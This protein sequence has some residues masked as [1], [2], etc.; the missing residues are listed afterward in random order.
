MRFFGKHLSLQRK[1]FLSLSL[2]TA[3]LCVFFSA[4]FYVH[5]TSV[6]EE[7]V[8]EKAEL[9]LVQVDAVQD[10]VRSVLRPRMFERHPNDFVIEAMSSSYISRN[11]MDRVGERAL[12]L[13]YRRVA[14]GARNEDSEANDIERMLI[15]RFRSDESLKKW[16]GTLRMRN[17][18][19]YVISRPVRFSKPCMQCHGSVDD[20]PV[21]LVRM[22]GNNGFGHTL[23]G[24]DGLDFIAFPAGATEAQLKGV[25]V[26]YFILFALCA[27]FFFTAALVSFRILVVRRLYALATS[28]R[29][30]LN[31]G[32]RTDIFDR[33]NEKDEVEE[34][35]ECFEQVA[36]HLVD[37]RLQLQSYADNLKTMV[38]ARTSE[39]SHEARERQADVA[40]FVHLFEDM[41]GTRTNE[42]LWGI[43]LPRI[44]RRFGAQCIA[45]ICTFGARRHYIW[46]H[47]EAMPDLPEPLTPFIVES[48]VQV[49]GRTIFIPVEAQ[50]GATEG[51][52]CLVW[53]DE[54][55][56]TKQNLAVL[57]ALG[58]QLGTVAENIMAL[59]RVMRQMDL[60][61]A[62]FDGV[63]DPLVLFDDAGQV[64]IAND[65]ARRLAQELYEQKMESL[66]EGK[67][68]AHEPSPQGSSVQPAPTI[69]GQ[70]NATGNLIS[71]LLGEETMDVCQQVLQGETASRTVMHSHGRSFLVH[72][73]PV[74]AMDNRPGRLAAYVR[75]TTTERQMFERMSQSERL[76]SVGKLSAGLAH[77]INN[78][79]G[80]ILCY[81]ELLRQG[82]TDEQMADLDVIVRHTRQAQRVLRDLLNFARPKSYAGLPLQAEDAV[83]RVVEVFRPQAA[84]KGAQIYFDVQ[85]TLPTVGVGEQAL[86]QIMTNLI[87]NALDALSNN[88]S[89][90]I[91]S[92]KSEGI[93]DSPCIVV[94]MRSLNSE[95]AP[96]VCHASPTPSSLRHTSKPSRGICITVAD[97]G[98]GLD[99]EARQRAFDPFFTT[100]DTG[101]GLG[102]AVVYGAVTD[103]G[104]V[105]EVESPSTVASV[106][107]ASHSDEAM[108]NVDGDVVTGS[109]HKHAMESGVSLC[110]TCFSIFLPHIVESEVA[111]GYV[112]DI[113]GSE[114]DHE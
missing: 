100:K 71:L 105:I 62:V 91:S 76:A 15:D 35:V 53:N 110:G 27:I 61:Q 19:Y 26:S 33:L 57:G 22:Y 38:D 21:E 24:L 109:T 56:A 3:V 93:Q 89:V 72:L 99:S 96:A 8:R 10:Y 87:L 82:A 39:L 69:V 41:R 97:N 2:A 23:N 11:I 106:W 42:Q 12:G 59:D 40:L 90:S 37:A 7:Q 45:Y 74:P 98:C 112:S 51:L 60:L 30:T 95:D 64:V 70:S 9:A 86:E 20:A 68:E 83:R 14:I 52:L 81:A 78:P 104:G 92:V 54:Q 77:E 32:E 17:M 108:V 65:G 46:P 16:S 73:Y 36:N 1:F 47:G 67:T 28:F 6:V 107:Q 66:A 44:C 55:C 102:L 79:L 25:I 101:T 114:V 80:V 34:V 94:C 4:I 5:M 113:Q 88:D 50:H 43:V 49:Q 29:R 18:D 111:S 103:V 31:D 48:R 84:R 75:E 58:R 63:G 85:G 13:V